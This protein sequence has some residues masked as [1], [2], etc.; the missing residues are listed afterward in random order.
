[1]V[2][3]LGFISYSFL[4]KF[5]RRNKTLELLGAGL[6][7]GLAFLTHLNG[8]IYV[9]AGFG[10]LLVSK[11]WKEAVIFGLLACFVFSF[12][13]LDIYIQADL[14]TFWKQLQNDPSLEKGLWSLSNV[15][16]R[17]LMEQAR[18]FFSI[19]EIPFTLFFIIILI[20]AFNFLKESLLMS[21]SPR[22]S[23]LCTPYFEKFAVSGIERSVLML[24]V[25][26]SPTD[27]S[28]RVAPRTI[29]LFS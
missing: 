28:P 19:K 8:L 2:M 3:C 26:S 22:I 12:Y 4:E 6:F 1:M 10:L 11:Y 9:V 23:I 27:P 7:A 20:F 29:L 24:L 17:I 18:Y 5:L 21:A 15:L 16:E 25:I 13:F 14:L